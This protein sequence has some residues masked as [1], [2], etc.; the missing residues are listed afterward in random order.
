MQHQIVSQADWIAARKALLV[1]EKELSHARD[2]IS[3]LRR[4]L[5]WVKVDKAY[6]FDTPRGRQTLAELFGDRSQLI[7]N[8][9]MLG[10]GWKDGCVGCSFGADHVE[11]ILPHLAQ[12]DVVYVAVSRAPLAEIEAYRK[13]MGWHFDWVSSFGSDFNFDFNVSFRPEDLAPGNK[14][15]YNYEM[16]EAGI[17][18]LPGY[19]VFAKDAKGDV[20]HTY[21]S[22]GRGAEALLGTYAL[23][24][25][26]P[27]GREENGPTHSLMDWVKRHDEYATPAQASACCHDTAS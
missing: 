7:V 23:L 3:R 19:S 26:T 5:P 6:T 25:M 17:E 21:S 14:V 20:F 2:E 16:T 13:R 12:R 24:D 1:R 11:G 18:E 15:L 9:F 27:K 8:H 10:P 22:Y 4:A